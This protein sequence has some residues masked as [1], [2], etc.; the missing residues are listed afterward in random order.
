M[1]GTVTE[2]DVVAHFWLGYTRVE[3]H[4]RETIMK[5]LL[6]SGL[7]LILGAAIVHA[8]EKTDAAIE[9]A[10]ELEKVKKARFAETYVN[11]EVDFTRYSKVY[12]GDA[13]FDYRDVGP[14]KKSRSIHRNSSKS[15]FGISD[16]D[17][18]KFEAVVDKAFIKEMGKGKSFEITDTLDANTMIMRGAVVD[19]VSRVPP[20]F[21]GRSEV[22]LATVGEATL[23]LE[24]LDGVTGQVLATISER[25]AFGRP[26][27][28]I[29]MMSSP[30]NSV[31]VWSDVR[32]WA[33]SSAK[34]LRTELDAA[35][36]GK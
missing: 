22:Y 30:T 21:V 9:N 12:L 28:Q 6:I 36:S 19:I 34:R 23:V 25:R 35:M 31:T 18:E 3:T 4:L 27:G 16:A 15:V 1:P 24:F 33:T 32:R 20:E 8:G 29:D 26:G 14:A 13:F 2:P 7:V 11:R 5:N 10:P 17:R